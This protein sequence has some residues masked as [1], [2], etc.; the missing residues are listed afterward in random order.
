MAILSVCLSII[1]V[2]A[3]IVL[4]GYPDLSADFVTTENL[5]ILK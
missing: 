4:S 1:H 2:A 3:S 5:D